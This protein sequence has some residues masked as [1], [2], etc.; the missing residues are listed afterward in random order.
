M[1]LGGR[2][3]LVLLVAVLASGGIARADEQ[4]TPPNVLL[5]ITDDQRYDGMEVMPRTER[6]FGERGTAFTNAY[7]TT[8]LCCPSRAS[9]FTGQYAHN[10]GVWDN[11]DPSELDQSTTWPLALHRAG[12]TTAI[13]G[14]YLNRWPQGA[15]PEGFDEAKI[16]ADT[17]SDR[18][19]M[20]RARRFLDTAPEPWALVVGFH[21]GHEPW[22]AWSRYEPVGD[23]PLYPW[24]FDLAD[25]AS[26]VR[27]WPHLTERQGRWRWRAQRR[28]L[29]PADRRAA[30]L[31]RTAGGDALSMFLSDNGYLMGEH[32][33]GGKL[34]P[35]ME[36]VH[37]PMY[38]RG[39]GFAP[40]SV[41]DALVANIDLAPTI[42][43]ITGVE[44]LVPQDGRSLLAGTERDWLLLEG[45]SQ[46][47]VLG[48][49]WEKWNGYLSLDRE[50]VRWAGGWVE[51]YDLGSD[52]WRLEAENTADPAIDALLDEAATCW[53]AACP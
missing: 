19:T 14:K 21:A 3:V 26:V 46:R 31:A 10:H 50:Y 51:D 11:H 38:A 35:Y 23:S 12:Y 5:V 9:I 7:V 1:R 2:A 32:Q 49:P 6:A 18:N 20:R 28:E 53:A 22:D 29:I 24:E 4:Q 8:P 45:P 44:P 52:P 16:T 37:V 30:E 48:K 15:V 47:E 41:S 33:V 25:K 36:S 13:F 39:P 17:G 43:G 42:Y 27:D 40:G 34:W